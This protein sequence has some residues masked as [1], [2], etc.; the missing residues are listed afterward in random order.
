MKEAASTSSMAGKTFWTW[1]LAASLVLLVFRTVAIFIL[2]P[3]GDEI[4]HLYI[5]RDIADFSQFPVYFY[6]QHIMGTLECYFIAPFFRLFGFSFWAGRFYYGLLYLAFVALYLGVVLRLF[7]DRELTF[8][9]FLFLSALPFPALFFTTVIGW[10]DIVVLTAL[11]L[12]LALKAADENEQA[13][14]TCF[15]LGLVCGLALWSNPLFVIWMAPIGISLVWIIP[16]SWK[17]KLPFWTFLGLLIGLIPVWIHG[18]QTGVLMSTEDHAGPSFARLEQVPLMIFLFLVRMKYFLSSFSFGS[19]SSFVDAPV[20]YFSFVP[21]TLFVI[22]FMA[23][24]LYVLRSWIGLTLKEKIFYMFVTVPF[25]I[26]A[27]LYVSRDLSGDEGMRFFVQIL[28]PYVFALSWGIRRI[29]SLFWKRGILGLLVGVLLLGNLFSGREM[30]RRTSELREVVRVLEEKDLRFG[31]GQFGFSFAL[32][33][34]SRDR[35]TVTPLFY[36]TTYEPIRL[37]VKREGAQFLIWLRRDSELLR[38][39]AADPNLKRFSVGPYDVYYGD[40]DFLRGLVDTT[41]LAL[42]R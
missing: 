1:I 18:L 28:I 41:D 2:P 23:V 20:R 6:K 40:S 42:Y 21:F 11:S 17:R 5:A 30:L 26:L 36:Q 38:R 31:I 8:Y 15:W 7:K 19:V 25:F 9:L 24:I 13:F 33:I 10:L 12:V 29:R 27:V 4:T 37:K 32:N 39:A 22:S 35:L 14:R 16:L 34:L 3:G